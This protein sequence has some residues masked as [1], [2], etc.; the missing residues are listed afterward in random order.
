[1]E[2]LIVGIVINLYTWSNADFF[3]QKK[4]N[5]RQMTCH[6]VDEGWQKADPKNPALDVFGYVKY[7]QHCTTK[8]KY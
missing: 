1:M 5:E 2:T 8:E 7:K 4:N 3:V 6:W